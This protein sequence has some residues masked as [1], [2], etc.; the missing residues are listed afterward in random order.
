MREWSSLTDALLDMWDN[1]NNHEGMP[2][3][4]RFA[5]VITRDAYAVQIRGIPSIFD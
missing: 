3:E 5:R 4:G 1:W 2:T